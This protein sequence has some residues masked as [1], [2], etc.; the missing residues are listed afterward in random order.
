MQRIHKIYI[1]KFSSYEEATKNL[2]EL[3]N[4]FKG[5][6]KVYQIKSYLS[7]PFF[8]KRY[9][10]IYTLEEVRKKYSGISLPRFERH[11]EIQK[12]KGN[13][14]SIVEKKL[15]L[16]YPQLSNPLSIQSLA[17]NITSS[18]F[19]PQLIKRAIESGCLS[20][21]I[22]AEIKKGL[23]K[24]IH[25]VLGPPAPLQIEHERKVIALIGP[26]GVGKTTTCVKI[27]TKFFIERVPLSF[28]TLDLFR[29]GADQQLASFTEHMGI[30][31]RKIRDTNE[32]S[33]VLRKIESSKLIIIDTIGASQYDNEKLSHIKRILDMIKPTEMFL[34]IPLNYSY[35]AALDVIEKFSIFNFNRII[36]SKV[37]EATEKSYSLL[38]S[39][40]VNIP[41][42]LISYLTCGQYPQ[43]IVEFQPEKFVEPILSHYFKL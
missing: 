37:D 9:K 23:A 7:L 31:C 41:S 12:I 5:R 15:N 6:V 35:D 26:T 25:E 20:S 4:K 22:I 33:D 8:R 1:Q 18:F 42:A 38:F 11:K 36:I 16:L 10:V 30:R 39:I 32:V 28:I 14:E 40:R 21:D 34:V 17:G 13:V 29:A 19:E 43:D 2:I 3:N 27:G 24:T